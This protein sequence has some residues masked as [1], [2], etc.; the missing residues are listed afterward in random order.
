V[1]GSYSGARTRRLLAVLALDFTDAM[2]SWL[3][4][5]PNVVVLAVD[6]RLKALRLGCADGRRGGKDGVAEPFSEGLLGGR[7]GF[8]SPF[9]L[10]DGLR[11]GR[12]G[13]TLPPSDPPTSEFAYVLPGRDVSAGRSELSPFVLD[14]RGG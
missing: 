11:G 2:L 4:R 5:L 6:V 1:A 3:A 10:S 14:G 8:T 13:L 7:A 9:P 12:A